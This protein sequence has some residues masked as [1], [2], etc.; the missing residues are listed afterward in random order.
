MIIGIFSNIDDAEIT[1]NNLAEAGCSPQNISIVMKSKEEAQAFVDVPGPLSNVSV[2]ELSTTLMRLGLLQQDAEK[3]QDMV[4]KGGV[5]IAITT[6]T[7]KEAETAKE[8]LDDGNAEQIRV[9]EDQQ[10]NR[11]D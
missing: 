5:F 3:Y 7:K 11:R 6:F 9:L 4:R 10:A 8:M 2:D 1:L